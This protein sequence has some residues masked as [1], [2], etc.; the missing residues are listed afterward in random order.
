MVINRMD[1]NSKLTELTKFRNIL[2]SYRKQYE[3]NPEKISE[4]KNNIQSEQNKNVSIYRWAADEIRFNDD[5][6]IKQ[7]YDEVNLLLDFFESK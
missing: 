4:I 7:I 6:V 1:Y 3:K 5:Q 2:K